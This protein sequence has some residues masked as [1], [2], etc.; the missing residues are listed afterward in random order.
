MSCIILFLFIVN[1]CNFLLRI[2]LY[3]IEYRKEKKHD[4]N[5]DELE[6]YGEVSAIK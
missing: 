5:T 2:K 6:I 4:K 3:Q 1:N